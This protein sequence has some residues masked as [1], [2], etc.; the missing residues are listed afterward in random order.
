MKKSVER[1]MRFCK[2][3]KNFPEICSKISGI[4]SEKIEY[5]TSLKNL[6]LT[7][8]KFQYEVDIID[9][10]YEITLISENLI[11]NLFV[12][13]GLEYNFTDNYFDLIPN[14]EKTIRI[15][16][17]NFHSTSSFKESLRFISLYDTY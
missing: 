5:L 14:K 12:D 6:K 4:I 13:S 2:K 3:L 1:V 17:D 10:Y 15:Q 8:P 16:R 11:K 7:T 9:N